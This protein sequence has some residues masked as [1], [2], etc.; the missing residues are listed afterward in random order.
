M[1]LGSLGPISQSLI[2][3][4]TPSGER[5][6]HFGAVQM[7]ANLGNIVCAVSTST[8]SM[9]M[10][11]GTIQGWRFAFAFVAN[12]SILLAFGIFLYMPE[13]PRRT[14]PSYPSFSGE[15]RK[16]QR[17]LKIPTFRVLVAQGMF[18]SI[19]WS[20]MAFMIF[21]F[22]Y[23]GISDLGAS[24]LFSLSMLGGAVG[25]MLG[26]YVGDALAKWSPLHGR[27]LC[28]Q[29]S[30][31]AGIPLVAVVLCGVPHDGVILPSYC[32]VVF[33]FGVMSSWCPAGV[34]RPLLAEIVDERD[35]ASIFAWL[36]TIDGAFAALLGAPMVGHLAEKVFGY[37]PSSDLIAAMPPDQRQQNATALCHALM[38]CCSVP[39][40]ICLICY[41]FL[42]VTYGQDAGVKDRSDEPTEA[43]P[44]AQ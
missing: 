40:L 5:G 2:V 42:H 8:I 27:A 28:A 36:V 37:S 4:F 7:A 18:G 21:Y 41:G 20:A 24:M 39:W 29:I 14:N 30:V 15:M 35:R 16:L 31:A 22:Q 17:Y 25:G 9:H 44:L 11:Y 23:V 19:P 12:A 13:P 3:D 10:I 34:N 32:A 43:S 1:A 6:K 26:G 33:V 38:W